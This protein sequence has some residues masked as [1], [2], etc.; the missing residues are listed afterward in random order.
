MVWQE[1]WLLRC[2]IDSAGLRAELQLA[3]ELELRWSAVLQS[4]VPVGQ[5]RGL[6]N[7]FYKEWLRELGLFSL[8]ES[9]GRSTT[10]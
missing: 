1:L 3:D 10:T 2:V 7:K 9:E 8:E 6:E 5:R 4:K